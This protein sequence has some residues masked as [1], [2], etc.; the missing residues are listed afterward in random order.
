[1]KG[2]SALIFD[3]DG[4]IAE[5]EEL[6]R[7]AFNESFVR[8]GLDW[9][10]DVPLYARLL[11]VTGG[12]ERISHFLARYRRNARE[13][14]DSQIAALHRMKNDRYAE[15]LAGGGCELRAGVAEIIRSARKRGQLLAIATTTSRSNVEALLAAAF[16]KEWP[17]LFQTIVAGDD[18]ARKKPAP[19]VY[20]RVLANL[21]LPAA[22][23][24]AFEDSRN[25]LLAAQA[26]GV[27]VVITR[28]I[29]FG[30]DDFEG[31]VQVVDELTELG[32]MPRELGA[33][34]L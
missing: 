27:P 34:A 18:V 1:V 3:V 28:S 11:R 5:T 15:L 26:A 22:S 23:C 30:D 16:G 4:T 33:P 8:F 31:A 13:L 2:A 25:G 9:M 10:W 12:K 20:L 6:H 29:Y 14:S 7:R 21:G 17:A 24:L 19:D 32:E